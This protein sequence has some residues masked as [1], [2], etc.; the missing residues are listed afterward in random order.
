MPSFIEETGLPQL[1][2]SGFIPGKLSS[3]FYELETNKEKYDH[4][5]IYM[6]HFLKLV[7][8]RSLSLINFG[9]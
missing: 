6:C 2:A 8:L 4:I 7:L 1:V 9:E 5:Y 3:R